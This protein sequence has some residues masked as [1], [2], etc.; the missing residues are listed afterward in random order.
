MLKDSEIV[1]ALGCCAEKVDYEGNEDTCCSCSLIT[2]DKCTC[3]LSKLALDLINR[4]Q[5]DVEN[6]KQ[7]AEHQHSAIKDAGF[8]IEWLKEDKE[9][10]QAE[11]ERL[12]KEIDRLS[13]CVLY[14][15]GQIADAKAEAY[16]ECIEKAKS[17]LKNISKFDFHG[18][19]YY[20]VGEAFFNNLLKELVGDDNA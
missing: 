10:L 19:D 17:E 15:D 5:A 18:T 11:N 8:E 20:L 6:Y 1:K 14:H 9:K 12:D 3:T 16:K 13:Q 4:L 2:D 7:V